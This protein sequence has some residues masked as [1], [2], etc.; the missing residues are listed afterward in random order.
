MIE[1]IDF[2]YLYPQND[3]NSVH[4]K[5]LDGP[6]EGVVFKYGKVKVEEKDDEA[7][8]QF[9]FDVIESK[10]VKPKKLEKNEE[11]KNYIGSMLIE[12][13]SN[14]LQEQLDENG[15]TYTEESII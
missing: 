3:K 10:S 13:I 4:I 6:Y 1:G 14:G 15:T 5:F 9:A 11:F 7:Y 12:I 2:V 8:L